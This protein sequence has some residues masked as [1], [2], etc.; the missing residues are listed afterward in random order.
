MGVG[1]LARFKVALPLCMGLGHTVIRLFE[2][3]DGG[4]SDA[5]V[6]APGALCVVQAASGFIQALAVAETDVVPQRLTR[7]VK[8][9]CLAG[10]KGSP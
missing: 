2:G 4:V 3:S 8:Q 10:Q 7:F 9:K 5:A 6:V 1:A